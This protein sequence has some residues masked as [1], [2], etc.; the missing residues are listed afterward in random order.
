[1]GV[2]VSEIASI[3]AEHGL[4]ELN[5]IPFAKDI[6]SS[7]L[8]VTIGDAEKVVTWDPDMKQVVEDSKMIFGQY[9]ESLRDRLLTKKIVYEDELGLV[10]V[11]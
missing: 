8:C 10:E 5:L 9:L 4:K 3:G 6:D 1:V 11:Q 7:L 2:T